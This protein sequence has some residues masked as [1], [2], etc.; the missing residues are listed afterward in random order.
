M[1]STYAPWTDDPSDVS[2]DEPYEFV[3]IRRRK[4]DDTEGNAVFGPFEEPALWAR[5]S[6]DGDSILTSFSFATLSA[7]TDISDC[8]VSGFTVTND[9][10]NP[11]WT[12]RGDTILSG[13][14]WEDAPHQED[15]SQ[16]IWMVSGVFKKH[17]NAKTGAVT[18]DQTQ[19]WS[20]IQQ[21]VD[22]ADFEAIYTANETPKNPNTIP[23]FRKDGVGI[24]PT[25]LAAANQ[26]GWYD[27][28]YEV[29]GG[30]AIWMATIKGHSN[31]WDKDANSKDNWQI[32]KVKG[33]K[34]D[35]GIN[36]VSKFKS[37]VFK[38]DATKPDKPTDSEGSFTSPVPLGWNDTIPSGTGEVW[39]T[40]RTFASDGSNDAHWSD[41]ISCIDTE[42][43][44]Y[45]W[46]RHWTTI[47]DA[48]SHKPLKSAPDQSLT[49]AQNN[50]WYDSP[51][52]GATFMAVRQV[53][54]GVY[55]G[56][57]EVSQIKGEKGD[58]GING[59]SKFKSIVFKRTNTKPSA[60]TIGSYTEPVPKAEGWSDTV[61]T[62]D[63]IL[64]M[65]SRTFSSDGNN[66]PSWSEP[67][68]ATDN[69]YID[70]E[71]NKYYTT[72]E[73]GKAHLPSKDSP[74][75]SHAS[76]DS[77]Y[78]YDSPIEGAVLMAVRQVRNGEY[79]HGEDWQI[80]KIKG[81][82]GASPT[83]LEY[84]KNIFP[85]VDAS[86]DTATLRGFLGVMSGNSDNSDVVAFLNGS[87]GITDQDHGTLM[88][89]AGVE[90][91][92]QANLA[93]FRVYE[94]GTVCAKDAEIDGSVTAS[95]GYIGGISINGNGIGITNGDNGF[96]FGSD[97]SISINNKNVQITN[98]GIFFK[99]DAGDNVLSVVNKA[100]HSLSAFTDT[101]A[102]GSS[103]I[104]GSVNEIIDS[105]NIEH[106]TTISKMADI[107]LTFKGTT[108]TVPDGYTNKVT[109]TI[110][111]AIEGG[112]LVRE[113]SGVDFGSGTVTY[114]GRVSLVNEG[115]ISQGDVIS[116]PQTT[117]SAA[118]C[119]LKTGR[120]SKTFTVGPGT[121][122]LALIE[123]MFIATGTVR[124]TIPDAGYH[125]QFHLAL[126]NDGGSGILIDSHPSNSGVEIFRNGFAIKNSSTNY[127][128]AAAPDDGEPESLI[129]AIKSNNKGVYL[130]GGTSTW[131]T[132]K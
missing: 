28:V 74:K 38:R 56:N 57:W 83:D 96:F 8:K 89:A 124:G 44:D 3:S 29:P 102:G 64:W 76:P 41:V 105:N 95:T 93:K 92:N 114:M 103:T 79:V 78:W 15:S 55:K 88:I 65:S 67:S 25:W 62:G 69:E 18:I 53:D 4:Y 81:E 128:F 1:E 35:S 7:G 129:F 84:L 111:D 59:V 43:V 32:M 99:N 36:G 73:E 104:R 112:L 12:K 16:I 118:H 47:E 106:A 24:D 131:Q 108:F 126:D 17:V 5:W 46:T 13:I 82:D 20:P 54:N 110:N 6:D 113:T 52:S 87:S 45:E 23:N 39:T 50:E 48:D 30:K 33:E 14:N 86:A 40:S 94:D 115:N 98:E 27:E 125:W 71:W 132:L 9:S 119:A 58:P 51:I 70:Y 107:P 68:Q 123:G 60:P 11:K 63:T 75:A 117:V 61:P 130:S 127:V 26:I 80:T 120:V 97:G 109:V 77:N 42:Y 100:Y 101:M 37:I 22:T 49:P 85:N 2:P 21:M 116:F 19:A 31:I 34:G 90:S 91:L 122:H 66:D 121:Y 10:I 72:V